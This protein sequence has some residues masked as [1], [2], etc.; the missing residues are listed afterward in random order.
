MI[1]SLREFKDQVSTSSCVKVLGSS[2]LARHRRHLHRQ[3]NFGVPYIKTDGQSLHPHAG[4]NSRAKR[5]RYLSM[6]IDTTAIHF[7]L[8]HEPQK[9]GGGVGLVRVL[10]SIEQ[11]A[12]PILQL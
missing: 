7:L 1:Y 5:L 4:L 9:A 2:R 11:V 6:V 10:S 12:Y 8:T 3:F